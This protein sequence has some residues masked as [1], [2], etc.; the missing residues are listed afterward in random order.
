MRIVVAV[1]FVVFDWVRDKMLNPAD[2]LVSVATVTKSAPAMAVHR[3][4]LV[5]Y[6][7]DKGSLVIKMISLTNDSA[8]IVLVGVETTVLLLATQ[9]VVSMLNHIAAAS[10]LTLFE[11]ALEN[12]DVRVVFQIHIA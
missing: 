10:Y 1:S 9:M 5:K 3:E 4:N 11:S 6:D 8:F 7:R 2:I 12:V